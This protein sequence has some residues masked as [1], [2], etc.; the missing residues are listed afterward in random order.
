[1]WRNGKRGFRLHECRRSKGGGP[2]ATYDRTW[3]AEKRASTWEQ[4]GTV[5]TLMWICCCW[6]FCPMVLGSHFSLSR[7]HPE[8]NVHVPQAHRYLWPLTLTT[9]ATTG[10]SRRFLTSSK[11][12]NS[13]LN[14]LGLICPKRIVVFFIKKL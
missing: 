8:K 4:A 13:F 2:R 11:N 3:Q 14:K 6:C 1:M 9:H 12:Y 10:K 5:S 7:L